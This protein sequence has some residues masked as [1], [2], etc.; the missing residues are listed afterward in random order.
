MNNE[1]TLGPEEHLSH[2]IM[3]AIG[4]AGEA[5]MCLGFPYSR[6]TLFSA[7]KKKTPTLS[8]VKALD[9]M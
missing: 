1:E 8:C 9:N 5:T 2:M 3:D 6:L 7:V 4:Y